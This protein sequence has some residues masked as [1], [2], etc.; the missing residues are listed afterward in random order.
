MSLLRSDSSDWLGKAPAPLLSG[1]RKA[2]SSAI[3]SRSGSEKSERLIS[4]TAQCSPLQ[5][6]SASHWVLYSNSL[7]AV[8]LGPPLPNVSS[9]ACSGQFSTQP[10]STNTQLALMAWTCCTAA[11]QVP[12]PQS[13]VSPSSRIAA[14]GTARWRPRMPRAEPQ[15]SR[16]YAGRSSSSRCGPIPWPQV[17]F[18]VASPWPLTGSRGSD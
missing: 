5:E 18:P 14:Y 2:L 8:Q 9:G 13:G 15:Q 11:S 3:P 1:A 17:T 12:P 6:P 4:A 10:N 16:A 7:G